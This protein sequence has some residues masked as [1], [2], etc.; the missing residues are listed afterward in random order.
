MALGLY[1][2]SPDHFYQ[3]LRMTLLARMTTGMKLGGR[4]LEDYRIVHLT[5]SQNDWI[6]VLHPRYLEYSPGLRQFCGKAL[7]EVW[8]SLLSAKEKEKF[9]CGHWD[10]SIGILRDSE[11]RVYLT[12]RYA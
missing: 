3:L 5:H 4:A 10:K 12:E 8:R 7:H 2:L 11:L 9:V 1:D 6:N